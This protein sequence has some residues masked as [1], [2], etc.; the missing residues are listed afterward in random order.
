MQQYLFGGSFISRTGFWPCL[1]IPFCYYSEIFECSSYSFKPVWKL[2]LSDYCHIY[3]G[4]NFPLLHTLKL[5]WCWFCTVN[6]SSCT[7]LKHGSNL[8][9]CV[10]C[11]IIKRICTY[12][13]NICSQFGDIH[14]ISLVSCRKKSYFHIFQNLTTKGCLIPSSGVVYKCNLID[15]G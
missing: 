7:F 10:V 9:V 8:S 4:R 2:H 13:V 11:C 12:V 14:A 1:D 3:Q 5:S 6:V 15:L